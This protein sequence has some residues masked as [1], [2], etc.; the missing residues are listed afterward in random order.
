MIRVFLSFCF[1]IVVS[2]HTAHAQSNPDIAW[3]QIEAQ[4]SLTVAQ[5]RAQI[6]AQDIQDVN[7]FSLG[8][9]WYAI[10]LGP[11]TASDAEQVLNVYRTEGLIPTDSFLVDT[12]GFRSQ[13][14]PVGANVLNLPAQS[15]PQLNTNASLETVT[16]AP[17]PEPIDE[18]PREARASEAELSKNIAWTC[19][20]G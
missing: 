15:G 7:G 12:T 14:W 9:G 18:T 20:G 8:G 3:V 13:F 4:P 17:D 6:Y 5:S 2:L 16:T 1:A 10:A 11:Y 19:R